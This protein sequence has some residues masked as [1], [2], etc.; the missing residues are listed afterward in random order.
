VHEYTQP[1][2]D[3]WEVTEPAPTIRHD[4]IVA[5]S[6]MIVGGVTIGPYAYVAASAV[7]TRDVPP[8]HVA[9]GNNKFIPCQSWTGG[10]LSRLF[11]HWKSLDNG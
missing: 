5:M 8:W 2:L 7:V 6:A 4:S 3:W 1:H 11:E 10:K 9:V